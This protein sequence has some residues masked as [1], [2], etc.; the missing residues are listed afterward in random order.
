M[1]DA[2]GLRRVVPEEVHVR[3]DVVT[4]APF[5]LGRALQVERIQR[6]AH[7]LERGVRNVDPELG[8]RFR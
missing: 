3:H 6:G 8:L 7:L 4:E 1:D 5:V 2:L